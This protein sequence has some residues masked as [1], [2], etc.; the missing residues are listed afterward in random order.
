[1]KGRERVAV[2]TYL[3]ITAL[4]AGAV[5]PVDWR[6]EFGNQALSWL[7]VVAVL[8][9][10]LHQVLLRPARHGLLPA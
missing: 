8:T 2:G 6:F 7:L 9:T 4:F 10:G 3:L 5:L 1:M